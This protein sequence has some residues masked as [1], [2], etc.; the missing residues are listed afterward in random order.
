MARK[1]NYKFERMERQRAK[2]A[3]KAARA[4]AKKEKADKRK[5][6]SD[7]LVLADDGFAD[8]PADAHAEPQENGNPDG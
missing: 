7:G 1:P 3:K 4:E 2:T 8:N 5:A 6:E